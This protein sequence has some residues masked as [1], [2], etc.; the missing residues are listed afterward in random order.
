MLCRRSNFKSSLPLKPKQCDEQL[1]NKVRKNLQQRIS[2]TDIEWLKYVSRKHQS[3]V[4]SDLRSDGCQQGV[5]VLICFFKWT[6]LAKSGRKTPNR[7]SRSPPNTNLPL[8]CPVNNASDSIKFIYFNIILQ[9]LIIFQK[10]PLLYQ[11]T[12]S[13]NSPAHLWPLEVFKWNVV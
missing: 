8:V 13:N 7:N 3:E 12:V 2:K 9:T 1:Q 4:Q 10:F 11:Y 5:Q 6:W